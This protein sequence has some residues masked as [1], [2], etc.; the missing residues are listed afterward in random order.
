MGKRGPAKGQSG[1]H[2]TPLH[3]KITNGQ[4]YGAKVLSF[5]PLPTDETITAPKS[6]DELDM[7]ESS[8]TASEVFDQTSEWLERTRCRH[9]ILDNNIFAYSLMFS[10]WIYC[11]R[12][13]KEFGLL[14]KHNMTGQASKSPYFEMA[15]MA[16]EKMM[17][18]WDKIWDVVLANSMEDLRKIQNPGGDPMIKLLQERK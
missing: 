12:K 9:L 14:S 16:F 8:P 2:T 13:N 3:E 17:K 18:A 5:A 4:E 10:R 7:N 6:L 15:L 11:E 1:G